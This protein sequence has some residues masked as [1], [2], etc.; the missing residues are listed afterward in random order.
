[1]FLL[2]E[3]LSKYKYAKLGFPPQVKWP[4]IYQLKTKKYKINIEKVLLIYK[5]H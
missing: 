3:N 2:K 1:M 5:E 4:Q